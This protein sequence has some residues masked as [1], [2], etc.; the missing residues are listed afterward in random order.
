VSLAIWRTSNGRLIAQPRDLGTGPD[1][2]SEL[3]F[4]RDGRLLAV[5]VPDTGGDPIASDLILDSTTGQLRQTLQPLG[6]DD[7]VS[8]AF[9]PNGTLA[10]G[11]QGG[12]VQLWNPIT[13][14]QIAGPVAVAAGP[15]TSIGFDSTGQRL[16]TTGGQ[17]GTVKLWSTSA[18][19]QE[20]VAL[21]TD[22]G[23]TSTAAFEPG[24][25]GLLVIDDRGNG[26]TWPTSI[27]TWGQHACAVAGRNLTRDEWT[28]YLPGHSYTRVCP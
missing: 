21:N 9:A 19:Q 15:V 27:A 23:A 12:I 14:D 24:D 13:G 20:G 1:R 16:A 26:F 17:D 3:A 7:T 4:S 18:L 28:R 8:L 10:T 6:A 25:A 2:Y 5:S 22:P 11:T